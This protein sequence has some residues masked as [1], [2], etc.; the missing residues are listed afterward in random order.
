MKTLQ[1]TGDM[2]FNK[3]ELVCLIFVVIFVEFIVLNEIF[4]FMPEL[5]GMPLT[6]G[7]W[8]KLP[9][10][11]RLRLLF[12]PITLLFFGILILSY[13]LS[14]ISI[15]IK[16]KNKYRLINLKE[17]CTHTNGVKFIRKFGT[18]YDA[19]RDCNELLREAL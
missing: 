6:V 10:E 2:K 9:L 5:F 11:Q 16:N 14:L 4:R 13:A 1:D 18:G 19:C 15:N 17:Q 12:S 8:R 7:D 3:T